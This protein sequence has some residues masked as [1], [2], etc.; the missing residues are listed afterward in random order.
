MTE[1][2]RRPD[3]PLPGAYWTAFDAIDADARNLLAVAETRDG[4]VGCLQLT[5]VPSLGH[6]G[7]ERALIES[8]SV[9][10]ARIRIGTSRATWRNP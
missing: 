8:V 1:D 6:Q 2:L 4:V 5:Y 9:K 3:D 7:A 10:S